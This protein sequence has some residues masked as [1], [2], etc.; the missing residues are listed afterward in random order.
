MLTFLL[1]FLYPHYVCYLDNEHMCCTSH[2]CP[3]NG[4]PWGIC[5]VLRI[6][7]L[8]GDDSS[9]SSQIEVKTPSPK[10][11]SQQG[12]LVKTVRGITYKSALR[13]LDMSIRAETEA[14]P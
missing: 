5:L 8:S 13:E 7:N 10:H 4:H 1:L 11:R 6:L 2:F 14:A 9:Y 12:Y 3:K